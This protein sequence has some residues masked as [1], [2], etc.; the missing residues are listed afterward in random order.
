MQRHKNETQH[1]HDK[2]DGNGKGV[3][4]MVALKFVA[5]AVDDTGEP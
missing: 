1:E 4:G 5:Y 3:V 2:E